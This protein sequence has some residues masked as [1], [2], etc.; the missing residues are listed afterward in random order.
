MRPCL[1]GPFY[2][3]KEYQLASPVFLITPAFD[4]LKE[5][6]LSIAH[7]AAVDSS[8][9]C[10]SM[11][12]ISSPSSP[13]Y[14]PHAKYEFKVLSGGLFQ[15]KQHHGAI[16]LKHFCNAAVAQQRSESD[17]TVS[18]QEA[19]NCEYIKIQRLCIIHLY[20]FLIPFHHVCSQ[21]I[22][23]SCI[24]LSFKKLYFQCHSAIQFILRYVGFVAM[25]TVN[26]YTF[27]LV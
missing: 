14:T 13:R 17:D 22:P 26:N 20:F 25:Y 11:T 18:Q 3:P 8:S 1:S 7:Y 24:S 12:F 23:Y 21:T 27:I 19:K 16:F 9:D 15:R 10:D 6:R 4:F 2:L 5:V